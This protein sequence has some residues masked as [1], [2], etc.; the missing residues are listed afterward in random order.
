MAGLS[1]EIE[2]FRNES[3][4]NKPRHEKA[5][6]AEEIVKVTGQGYPFSYWLKW[7]KNVE[8]VG[9]PLTRVYSLIKIANELHKYNK[10]GF[11]TN[12]FKKILDEAKKQ[13]NKTVTF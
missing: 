13:K 5:V 7:L 8:L 3:N 6:I 12:Q 1:Q 10:G 11:L 4:K 2:R 9:Y